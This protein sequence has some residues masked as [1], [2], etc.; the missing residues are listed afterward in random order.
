MTF[1]DNHNKMFKILE[2]TSDKLVFS[3]SSDDQV[4]VGNAMCN[5]LRRIMISEVP[6]WA[7]DIV[8]IQKNNSMLLDDILAHRLG[9]V[10]VKVLQSDAGAAQLEI[11]ITNQVIELNVSYDAI[12]ADIYGIQNVYTSDLEYDREMFEIDPNI[13]IVRL[14]PNQEIRLACILAKD[15]G[16]KHAKWSPVCATSYKEIS[17]DVTYGLDVDSKTF[18]FKIETVGQMTP[19]EIFLKALDIVEQ[20]LIDIK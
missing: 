16:H 14:R 19:I 3:L 20:K 2:N 6:T 7:I 5:A 18:V 8:A 13:L 15:T 9:L 10:P 1:A 17:N 4:V 11:D 12:K